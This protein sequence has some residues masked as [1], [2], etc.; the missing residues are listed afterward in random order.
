[1]PS[2]PELPGLLVP[3]NSDQERWL[4]RHVAALCRLDNDR[5]VALTETLCESSMNLVSRQGSPEVSL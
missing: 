1:M 4:K 5:Y 2:I 3:H